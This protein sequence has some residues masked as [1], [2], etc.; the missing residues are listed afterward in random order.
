[1]ARCSAES[2]GQVR[3]KSVGGNG[4]RL[5]EEGLQR[6]EGRGTAAGARSVYQ[7]LFPKVSNMELE[8][9]QV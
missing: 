7:L 4:V 8:E 6:A 3:E 1:M 2:C 5:L 9:T